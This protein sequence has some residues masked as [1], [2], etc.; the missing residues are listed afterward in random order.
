MYTCSNA[1]GSAMQY[2]PYLKIH[3]KYFLIPQLIV[4]TTWGCTRRSILSSYLVELGYFSV[5]RKQIIK[6]VLRTTKT[7]QQLCTK[8]T[9]LWTKRAMNNSKKTEF[10]NVVFAFLTNRNRCQPL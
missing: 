7:T 8:Y 10:L 4:H 5:E 6:F 9:G 3:Y 1:L 2:T